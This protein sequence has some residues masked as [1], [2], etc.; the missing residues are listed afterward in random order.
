MTAQRL[1]PVGLDREGCEAHLDDEEF[2]QA[3]L[4]LKELARAV[5]G[6]AQG[7]DPRITNDRLQR[8]QI[9]E[10]MPGFNRGKGNR[11]SP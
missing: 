10:T 2:E 7:N 9:D 8:L 4:E 5:C 3:V 6:F 11:I 1:G